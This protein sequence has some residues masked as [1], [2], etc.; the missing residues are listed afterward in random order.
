MNAACTAD[1]GLTRTMMANLESA[2]MMG[3]SGSKKS[4]DWVEE[5]I[6]AIDEVAEA[7]EMA[8]MEIET[9]VSR[10]AVCC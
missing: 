7:P 10:K 6:V 5:K 8:K 2:V 4:D 3:H 1:D 9:M